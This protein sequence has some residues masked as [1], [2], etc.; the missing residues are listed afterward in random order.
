MISGCYEENRYC[1]ADYIDTAGLER[2]GKLDW[3]YYPEEVVSELMLLQRGEM[4][5]VRYA[6]QAY[7]NNVI[8]MD[9]YDAFIN[10]KGYLVD[11]AGIVLVCWI[12]LILHPEVMLF[13]LVEDINL[14]LQ[15][16]WR[17]VT[18]I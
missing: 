11:A 9:Q 15:D 17:R 13:S 6:E 1:F 4:V 3:R 5:E 18:K 14:I 16:K 7:E 12:I 10:Y 2:Y 8:L